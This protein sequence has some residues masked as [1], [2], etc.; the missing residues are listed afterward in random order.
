[1]RLRAQAAAVVEKVL[2]GASLA[3]VLPPVQSQFPDGRDQALLQA[4]CYGVC[5]WQ[6]KL[7]AMLDLLLDKPLKAKDHDIYCFL[8]VGLYQLYD[9]RIP[10]HAAVS[11]TVSA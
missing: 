5:R 11:E 4:I 3:D 8:L 10:A 1:M 9:M 6:K 7:Q 2:E